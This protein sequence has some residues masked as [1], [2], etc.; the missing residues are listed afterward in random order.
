[1]PCKLKA[2][3]LDE[4]LEVIENIKVSFEPKTQSVTFY[5]SE[6][7][8]SMFKIES[9]NLVFMNKDSDTNISEYIYMDNKLYKIVKVSKYSTYSEC[10][11]YQCENIN[12]DNLNAKSTYST[13]YTKKKE[14]ITLNISD[15]PKVMALNAMKLNDEISIPLVLK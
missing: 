5:D 3:L 13:N 11:V 7:A 8:N 4:N 10:L 1:M 6:L 9:T 2:M 12:T 14:P 15:T